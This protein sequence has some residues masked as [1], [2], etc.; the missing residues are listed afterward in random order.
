MWEGADRRYFWNYYLMRHFIKARH[1]DWV[2]P[3]IR[4]YVGI[5]KSLFIPTTYEK[6]ELIV[7][8]RNSCMR[9]LLNSP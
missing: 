6:I 2:V 7:L 5:D 8:S 1:H 9:G 3:V 4:G